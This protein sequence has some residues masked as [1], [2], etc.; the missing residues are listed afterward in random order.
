MVQRD[1]RE[2]PVRVESNVSRRA[3][4][5]WLR[6]HDPEVFDF[7]REMAKQ[8]DPNKIVPHESIRHLEDDL[9]LQG[10]LI[11]HLKQAKEANVNG[12][13]AKARESLR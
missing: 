3:L 4:A 8:P 5:E 10:D 7:I 11:N 1:E 2:L 6:K 12:A 13:L 9:E